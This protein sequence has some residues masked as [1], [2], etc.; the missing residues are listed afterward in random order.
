MAEP[1]MVGQICAELQEENDVSYEECE[2]D[3]FHYLR[4]LDGYGLL[5]K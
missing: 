5:Q 2:H 4:E 3:V 1:Y